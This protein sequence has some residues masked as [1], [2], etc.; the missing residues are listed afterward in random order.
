MANSFKSG[1]NILKMVSLIQLIIMLAIGSFA[2][3][4]IGIMGASGAVVMVSFLY[5][6]L[7]SMHKAIGTTLMAT[8]I[9]SSVV[10]YI[11]YKNKNVEV[12]PCLWLIIGA[13]PASQLG[14]FISFKMH[15]T[16]LREI[17]GILLIIFGAYL[18]RGKSDDITKKFE[19]ISIKNKKWKYAVAIG[20]G[21]IVGMI[22]TIFGASGG[23]W[24]LATLL[25]L[26]N[27]PLHK[28][29]GGAAFLMALTALFASIAQARY[30]NVDF[31]AAILV[32]IGASI[33]GNIGAKFANKAAE[34]ILIRGIAIMLI[35]LGIFL[36]MLKIVFE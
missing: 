17:F 35:I 7:G 6:L 22:A 25:I 4:I 24:F 32:G 10:A 8:F 13:L 33:T 16:L 1:F 19:K 15:E 2:G 26:F 9:A 5:I 31:V 30:G 27:V 29:V 12:M 3:I 18:L 20:I 11:Y 34:K 28:A 23:I 14:A 36:L 21:F